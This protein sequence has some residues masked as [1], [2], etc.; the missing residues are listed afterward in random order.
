KLSASL[1]PLQANGRRQPTGGSLYQL[2]VR[3]NRQ[4]PPSTIHIARLTV[5]RFCVHINKL[6]DKITAN[7]DVRRLVTTTGRTWSYQ[8]PLILARTRI[9]WAASVAD[10]RMRSVCWFIAMSAN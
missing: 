6:L 1:R 4:A 2:A 10:N 7:H 9:C 3:Q 8:T 5:L